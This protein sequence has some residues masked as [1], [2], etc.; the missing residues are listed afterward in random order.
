M[1][2]SI[3]LIL[4]MAT[5]PAVRGASY[6][7]NATID[8]FVATG[9]TANL[10]GN[11]Y[12]GAG[13]LS[14]SAAGLP[15]GEL[16]S[17]VQFS[18]AGARNSFDGTFGPGQWS[19]QSATLQLTAAPANNGIFNAP[20]AGMFN[21]SWMQNDSWTEG[22]G[23]PAV[24]GVSGITFN[25]LQ[26]TFIS[27]GDQSLGTFSFSGA[28]NGFFTYTLGLAAGLAADVLAGDNV[29]LRL[30]AADS[31]VSGV[32]NSRNFGTA[33]NRPLLTI[34]AVPEPGTLAI[35]GLAAALLAGCTLAARRKRS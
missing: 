16:Q 28:T 3:T 32:F 17:V 6:N 25:S 11:N 10:S 26:S 2:P 1:R 15:Q 8:A 22:T 34:V 27:A 9:P 12:G 35:G 33:A 4:L 13:S 23:T 30:S 21:I 24:P 20:A 14:L 18:L 31:T 29:S 5:L 19:I 7:T